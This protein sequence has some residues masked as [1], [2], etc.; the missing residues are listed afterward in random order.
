MLICRKL[1]EEGYKLKSKHKDEKVPFTLKVEK[2]EY[3]SVVFKIDKERATKELVWPSH[4][5]N[6]WRKKLGEGGSMSRIKEEPEQPVVERRSQPVIEEA[7]AG[8]ATPEEN[9]A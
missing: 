5:F 2:G 4:A 1:R 6:I 8:D 7:R 9:K 3:T